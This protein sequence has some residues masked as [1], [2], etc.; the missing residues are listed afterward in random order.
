[1]TR[2]QFR[3][4]I[5]ELLACACQTGEEVALCSGEEFYLDGYMTDLVEH[6]MRLLDDWE[7]GKEVEAV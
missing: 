7:N 5:E 3:E 1:M 6:A 2:E 4:R